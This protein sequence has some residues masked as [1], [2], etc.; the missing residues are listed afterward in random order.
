MSV[1]VTAGARRVRCLALA[2]ALVSATGLAGQQTPPAPAQPTFRLD[3]NF[4]RVDMYPTIDGRPVTD[5]TRDEI[6]IREDGVPQAIDTV[7]YVALSR[8]VPVEQRRDPDSV[9]QMRAE[10]E[11][12]RGRLF[13]IYFDTKHT[14]LSGS[15]AIKRTLVTMLDRMLSP[16]DL[17][18]VMTPYMSP[19][20]LSFARKSV[21]VEGYLSKHWFWGE[22]DWMLPQDP[23][24]RQMADCYPPPVGRK[25]VSELAEELINRRREKVT[26]DALT[27]LTL[28]LRGLREE[29]KAVI[30]ITNGWLL[31]RPK[32][33]LLSVGE[34]PRLPQTGTTPTGRL[35]TD[36]MKDE[37]G[38]SET[39]CERE[40]QL[41]AFTNFYQEF[42]DLME[43]ANRGNV[44]FYPVDSR[45]LAASDS[46][47]FVLSDKSPEEEM[48]LVQTRVESLRTLAEN[49]DGLA[50]VN[51]NA[52]DK[53][54]ACIVEDMTSYYLVGYYSSNTKLDGRYR[55]ISVK[56][57][58]PGVDVRAR[59]GYKAITADELA[60]PKPSMTPT[61]P[62]PAVQAALESLT[63][64]RSSQLTTAVGFARSGAGAAGP[65]RMWAAVELDAASA[66]ADFAEGGDIAIVAASADGSVLSQ[67]RATLAPSTR[68]A[69]VD[70]G[71]VAAA[72]ADV[73]VRTRVK[74][75]TGGAVLSDTAALRAPTG[76]AALVWRR[77]PTTA[78]K[79]VPSADRRLSR[80]DRIRVEVPSFDGTAPTAASLLDRAGKP[81]ALEVATGTRV[82]GTQTWSTGELALAALAAGDYVFTLT[83]AGPDGPVDVHTGIRVTQ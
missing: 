18:A 59:R 56:V 44:S 78:M 80:A 79:F 29:R 20:D 53:G 13:V 73:V 16:D 83:V 30:A 32:P 7:E 17:F 37:Y 15:H 10:A 70:L 3:A 58:R 40:R 39:Q 19:T 26:L 8:G 82:D 61:G 25:L 72:G 38:V 68:T 43:T 47:V 34:A 64:S 12:P 36:R 50:V 23:A 9:R 49:T 11:N 6:E 71:T 28:Y 14:T 74:P 1:V 77:G 22:R 33:E 65:V 54:V 76:G 52:L 5:L 69:L 27:D 2:L 24:E 31:P 42:Q 55:K 66:K 60:P 57:K 4:V 21:T 62:G 51:T 63:S 41:L 35:T 45:G 81:L 67:G 48:R 75:K 46:P